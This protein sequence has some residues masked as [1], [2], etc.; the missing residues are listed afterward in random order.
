MPWAPLFFTLVAAPIIGGVFMASIFHAF[1]REGTGNFDRWDNKTIAER[2]VLADQAKNIDLPPNIS[3]NDD[4]S[5]IGTDN[6]DGDCLTNAE[7]TSRNTD[8]RNPDTDGDWVDDCIEIANGTDP[9]DPNSG[10]VG[11]V[12]ITDT[13][14]TEATKL[15]IVKL[16]KTVNGSHLAKVTPDTDVTFNIHIEVVLTGPEPRTLV[17]ED[18]LGSGFS[19]IEGTIDGQTFTTWVPTRQFNLPRAGSYTFDITFRA[20]VVGVGIL[21]NTAIVY[22]QEN[23]LNQQRETAFVSSS[24]T[25]QVDTEVPPIVSFKKEVRPVNSSHWGQYAFVKDEDTVEFRLVTQTNT[26]NIKLKDSLPQELT[27]IPNTFKLFFNGQPQSI[28]DILLR[29]IFTPVGY[30]LPEPAGV[31]EIR[32]SAKVDAGSPFA[33]TNEATATHNQTGQLSSTA[34]VSSQP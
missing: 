21:E 27:Y 20:K 12:T 14:P 33:L 31:Y 8:P 29:P 11:P 10:G 3:P 23:P 6:H 9:T 18:R 28:S 13:S 19:F 5:L 22:E 1:M 32:F 26:A 4:G 25:T 30:T 7:E 2:Q 24:D 16:E 15:Y 17:L 34:T